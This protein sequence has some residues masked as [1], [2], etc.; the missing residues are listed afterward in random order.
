MLN[1]HKFVTT[2]PYNEIISIKKRVLLGELISNN[3][4][5]PLPEKI[6]KGK[7]VLPK[8]SIKI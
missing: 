7:P 8:F 1:I 6:M 2:H 4:P 3:R 5:L